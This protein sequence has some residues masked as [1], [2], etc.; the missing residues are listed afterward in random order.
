MD[1][2][3]N[4]GNLP[5]PEHQSYGRLD[6]LERLRM[7]RNAISVS[8]L[9]T[10]AVRPDGCPTERSFSTF[11]QRMADR[12]CARL[13]GGEPLFVTDL[14]DD[15]RL[16]RLYLNTLPADARGYHS[17][18]T[19]KH[20]FR[21][22]AGLV[23]IDPDTGLTSAALWDEDTAPDYYRYLISVLREKVEK[24]NVVG[25]FVTGDAMLGTWKLPGV[26][27]AHFHMKVPKGN[28]HKDRLLAPHE[29]AARIDEN[30]RAVWRALEEYD[31]KYLNQAVTILESGDLYRG[32][33]ILG[34]VKWLRD[35]Q[36]TV[37]GIRGK[38]RKNNI[39]IRR[40]AT[41]PE[42]FCHPRSGMA[43]T[44]LDDLANGTPLRVAKQ[45][46]EEKMHPLKY[47]RP[48]AAPKAGN[49]DRAE[50]IVER[51]G[52][53]PSLE[54]RIATVEDIKEWV[55]RQPEPRRTRAK[56]KAERGGVFNDLKAPARKPA[57]PQ[58]SG[59][60]A[61]GGNITWAKFS[62]QVL[63]KANR[64]QV[65]L[66]GRSHDFFTLCEAV[67]P[68]A[69]PILQWDHEHCRN[70]MSWYVWS[71]GSTAADYGLQTG[72]W[73]DIEGFILKPCNWFGN[74]HHSHKDAIVI[75][76]DAWDQKAGNAGS[77]LFPEIL[78]G[79][80]HEVRST[81]EAY[82]R[83]HGMSYDEGDMACGLGI[84]D[85]GLKTADVKVTTDYGDTIYRI[86]R[87]D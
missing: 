85:H 73:L 35:L 68:E 10:T 22:W 18:N 66:R 4:R 7:Q 51:L 87:W 23:T 39:I 52:I 26:K 32:D 55:W 44:L 81:I 46:F 82:S 78:K 24:A 19:C 54:R 3:L 5:P 47:Q 38:K 58:H 62:S 69:P 49:I 21:R 61:Q 8:S 64:V 42:G 30:T 1:N 36:D 56:K 12:A 40:V 50:A 28:L 14:C 60:P 86:D 45:R 6:G 25:S 70:T 31:L 43:G 16:Y 2:V 53:A 71:G 67:H 48:T 83:S 79:E 59:T 63:P 17:C 13:E 11:V 74:R 27:W 57:R 33:Q 9:T 65:I 72:V 34:G 77:G 29:K 41:A 76:K 80:L 84:S 15:D 20:F 75:I 37:G